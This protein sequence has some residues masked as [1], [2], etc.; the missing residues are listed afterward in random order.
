MRCP[1]RGAH[2]ELVGSVGDPPVRGLLARFLPVPAEAVVRRPGVE[3]EDLSLLVDPERERGDR[4]TD[5]EPAKQTGSRETLG[6]ANPARPPAPQP[7]WAG[8]GRRCCAE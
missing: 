2:E 3:P 6:G 1:G 7:G 8:R 5:E 4:G